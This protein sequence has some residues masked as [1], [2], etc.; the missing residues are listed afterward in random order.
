MLK[1]SFTSYI[2]AL[3]LQCLGVKLAGF[4]TIFKALSPSETK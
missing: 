3:N 1:I 4:H 2:L